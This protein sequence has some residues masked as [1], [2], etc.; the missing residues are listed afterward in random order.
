MIGRGEVIIFLG[1]PGAGKG[2]QAGRLASTLGIP[3]I[4]TGEMLR[5][6]C[7]SGSELGKVVAGVIASGKLVSDELVNKIVASRLARADC[8]TG[9]IL[10]GY[11]RTVRQARFLDRF[12]ESQGLASPTVIHLDVNC[13]EILARLSKR[14]QCVKCGK[15][16][17]FESALT[18]GSLLCDV[19]GELLA[20][21]VDD[22]PAVV[23]HRLTVYARNAAPLVRYY[24]NGNYHRI[25]AAREPEEVSE[26]ILAVLAA[27]E[28][29]HR[30]MGSRRLA[31]ATGLQA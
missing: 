12:L 1:P 14:R 17:R 8:R 11:P 16:F 29:A 31:Y 9:C 3:A 13:Q 10:D 22:S 28:P 4:S 5:E 21:R 23:Q 18:G 26:E 30:M 2:T 27:A 7:R 24:T 6:E 25:H 15:I 20:E 19:D